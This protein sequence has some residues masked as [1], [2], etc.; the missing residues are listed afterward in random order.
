MNT[1]QPLHSLFGGSSLF[2]SCDGFDDAGSD[3]SCDEEGDEYEEGE[4]C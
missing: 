1:K 4:D 2:N 3:D